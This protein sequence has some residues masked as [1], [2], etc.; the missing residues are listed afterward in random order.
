MKNRPRWNVDS[1]S[2][3]GNNDNRP[4]QVDI[5]PKCNITSDSQMVK[6]QN[7]WSGSESC[8]KKIDFFEVIAK[9][10]ERLTTKYAQWIHDKFTMF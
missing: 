3:I 1:G 5:V 8:K 7:M 4:A 9:F 10:Y 2:M 6:F